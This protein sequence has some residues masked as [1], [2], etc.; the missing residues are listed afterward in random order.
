MEGFYLSFVLF[1]LSVSTF[2]EIYRGGDAVLVQGNSQLVRLTSNSAS[3]EGSVWNTL[4]MTTMSGGNLANA[5]FRMDF[6]FRVTN[7]QNPP[8]DGMAVVLQDESTTAIGT[9][10]DNMGVPA[11]NRAGFKLDWYNQAGLLGTTVRLLHLNGTVINNNVTSRTDTEYRAY[12]VEYNS[13]SELVTLWIAGRQPV[14]FTCDM[15]PEGRTAAWVGVTASTG[16]N[17]QSH[18]VYRNLTYSIYPLPAT[19]QQLTTSATGSSEL[20][21]EVA[22][23]Q[24]LS[25]DCL[26]GWLISGIEFASYGAPVGDCSGGYSETTMCHATNTSSYISDRCVGEET[27]TVFASNTIF[28]DP[29]SGIAKKLAVVAICSPPVTTRALTTKQ[30]TTKPLT[31]GELTTSPLTTQ[32]L[33]TK[34]LTTKEMTTQPLTTRELTTK[35]LTTQPLTTKPLTTQPL[36]TQP[37]T[38]QPLTTQEL[39]TQ[40]LTTSPLTTSPLTTRPVTTRTFEQTNTPSDSTASV[41]DSPDSG[42]SSDNGSR[43]G[44]IGGIVGG[45]IAMIGCTLTAIV[46]MIVYRK[47]RD[48]RQEKRN[49]L[50]HRSI[51]LTLWEEKKEKAMIQAR[52]SLE[53]LLISSFSLTIGLC[54]FTASTESDK[55]AKSLVHVFENHKKTVELIR[56]NIKAEVKATNHAGSLLRNNSMASKLMKAYSQMIG[57]NFLR[58]LLGD[59][60][61]EVCNKPKENNISCE[62]DPNKLSP[63]ENLDRNREKLQNTCSKFLRRIFDSADTFPL[64]FRQICNYLQSIVTKKFPESAQSCIG[65]FLFLRF[66]CAA[67]V[68]PHTNGLSKAPPNEYAQRAL[69]LIAKALQNVANNVTFDKKEQYMTCLNEFVSQNFASCQDFFDEMATI[70]PN[71]TPAPEVIISAEE[72]RAAL[73]LLQ[74]QLARTNIKMKEKYEKKEWFGRLQVV[75]EEFEKAEK[76]GKEDASGSDSARTTRASS[77]MLRSV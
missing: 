37:L 23:G 62:I 67:I 51:E 32:P 52:E 49:L 56:R 47:R 34:E 11:T 14:S 64:E 8:A 43:S 48:K 39:T 58:V 6:V 63:E 70:P 35:P 36:T 10:G 27:C 20:C 21:E 17:Y 3:Q 50:S 24:T 28:G 13:V 5:G 31:T 25:L 42:S 40:E 46:L 73:N 59:L 76:E 9:G 53:Q 29:C 30:L 1:L 65:G 60:V 54:K 26:S 71:A 22:E 55:V 68:V 57:K 74:Q 38:T 75:L 4:K 66:L 41:Q 12:R 61:Q 33:T 72:K 18:F 16:A 2:A 45:L 7:Q 19:T 15:Y 44:L 69:V 77:E